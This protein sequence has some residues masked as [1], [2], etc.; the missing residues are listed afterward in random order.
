L[1]DEVVPQFIHRY[2]GYCF[3]LE[4]CWQVR[5]HVFLFDITNVGKI[6][7]I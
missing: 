4:S 2:V 7:M 1:L 5:L 3:K 6:W